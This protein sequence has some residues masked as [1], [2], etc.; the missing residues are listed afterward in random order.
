MNARTVWVA[1]TC[2]AGAALP[3]SLAGCGTDPPVPTGPFSKLVVFGD[4]LTDTGNLKDVSQF[5]PSDPYYAGRFTNGEAWI[6]HLA[7]HFGLDARP[8]YRG[9]T[10]FALGA[11]ATGLGLTNYAGFP[12]APNIREQI[13]LYKGTPNGTE[14]FVIWAGAIDIFESITGECMVTMEDSAANIGLAVRDLY[15][16]GGRQFLVPNLP[17]IGRVP[18]Y[19][20]TPREAQATGLTLA[21]NT[22]LAATLDELSVLE[23]IAI[24]RLD[25]AGLLEEG[26]AHPPAGVANVT[27]PAWTGSLLGYLAGDGG[28]VVPEPDGHLFWDSVH[29][30]RVGHRLIGDAAVGAVEAGLKTPIR[31]PAAPAADPFALQP[32]D[33]W[34]TWLANISQSYESTDQCRY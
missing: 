17:D 4:S 6:E 7:R 23:G 1:V 26:I 10:N 19:R 24:Y 30:S 11:A 2:L 29:P 22:A 33:F 13:R 5:I 16:R 18:R 8:S 3:G 32:L 12:L 14:L 31:D 25:V 15:V 28:T 20:G 21:F 34:L 9:G 27:D